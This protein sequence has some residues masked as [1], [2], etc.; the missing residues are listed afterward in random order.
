MWKDFKQIVEQKMIKF[1]HTLWAFLLTMLSGVAVAQNN[2]NSPYTRYGFGQ[3]ADQGSAN[4]KAMGG[5]A[6]A[7]RDK[8]QVNFANPASYSSVDSLTFIFDGGI[9]LQ[10]TNFSNGTVKMNAKNSSFDY[11]TMQFRAAKWAG[12]SLG[13]LP[14]ANVGYSLGEFREDP[15]LET[16]SSSVTYTGEGG[17]HQLY[18]GAGFKVFKN[19]SVGANISYLWGGVTRTRTLAFPYN[20]N[21]FSTIVST[22]VDVKS[23]KL[24]FGAQY[25][26][27][28]GKKHSVTVGAVFS[29]G[30]NLKSDAYE[31]RQTGTDANATV[32]QTPIEGDFGIPT[33]WGAGV[34][35]T[36]DQRLTVAADGMLQNWDDV[37][38]EGRKDVFCKRGKLSVGAE[39]IPNPI[40]RNYLSRVKYR[41][42]G[43]YSKPYYKINGM[44][45][46]TEF[47]L[48][49]GFG[50][51][52]PMTRSMVSVS[53]QY[54]RTQGSH[55]AFLDENTLRICIG[56]TFNERWFFKRKVN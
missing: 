4:S 7:L 53:A 12:I 13:L 39:Y 52:V 20:S 17:L 49:A 27:Q 38:Y 50:L 29:P 24:D 8:H 46:A 21:M 9:S 30:H 41:V 5:V 11:I 32:S 47:G 19:L 51:P 43:Y 42:G 31:Y 15:E 36:Y 23:Y 14:Y 35:Y 2:T 26:Q 55:A 18:L 44:R 16:A 25:T 28:F 3:L 34:A 54:V 40:G 10:N 1:R 48:S 37:A 45:A 33:T 22:D 56:I 6:Y